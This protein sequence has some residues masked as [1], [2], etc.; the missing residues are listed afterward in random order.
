MTKIKTWFVYENVVKKG[1]FSDLTKKTIKIIRDLEKSYSKNMFDLRS[2]EYT[3]FLAESNK[4][5]CLSKDELPA[6]LINEKVVFTKKLPSVR[7]LKREVEW[8]M[9]GKK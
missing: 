7:D 3:R 1:K 5:V 6:T 4:E 2:I 8:T 9:T